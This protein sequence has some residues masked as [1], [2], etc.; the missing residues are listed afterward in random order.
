[1]ALTVLDSNSENA[2]NPTADTT[3]IS[4]TSG[5]RLFVAVEAVRGSGA[6]Q[7]TLS[8]QGTLTLS[9]I[10]M[11]QSQQHNASDSQVMLYLFACTHNAGSGAIRITQTNGHDARIWMVLQDTDAVATAPI[12]QAGAAGNG[13]GVGLPTPTVT[14]G[15]FANGNNRA[16]S[17]SLIDS[18]FSTASTAGSGWTLLDE[19]ARGSFTRRM[20]CQYRDTAD[21]S[22]DLTMGQNTQTNRWS[23]IAWEVNTQGG[24]GGSAA[25]L[26]HYYNMLRSA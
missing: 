24:G 13:S 16:I 11:F 18:N 19:E 6:E 9:N 21:T 20:A 17:I 22:V 7:P 25:R 2:G 12:Q 5:S 3:S 1:M 8:G 4:P 26:S 14:L 23:I 15:S 10:T